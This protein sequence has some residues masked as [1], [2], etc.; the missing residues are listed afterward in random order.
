MHAQLVIAHA[1][2][3]RGDTICRRPSPPPWPPKPSRAAEKTQRSSTVPR[4]IGS[5]AHRCSRLTR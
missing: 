4:R 5:N 3:A 2:H 1:Y